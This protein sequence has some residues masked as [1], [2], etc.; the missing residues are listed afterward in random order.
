MKVLDFQLNCLRH[1]EIVN[2][3]IC[4]LHKRLQN[5]S[6]PYSS[7]AHSLRTVFVAQLVEPLLPIPYIGS[8]NPASVLIYLPSTVL[9]RRKE[10][11]VAGNGHF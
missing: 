4:E 2:L 6:S 11:K 9:K 1:L 8:S 5:V 3:F 10:R 7:D